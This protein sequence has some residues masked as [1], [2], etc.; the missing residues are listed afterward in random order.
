[1]SIPEFSD[2]ECW[3]VSSTLKERYGDA[4]EMQLAEAE[5]RLDPASETTTPCPALYWQAQ[6]V[7]FAVFKLGAG[8]FRGMF[9]YSVH[10]QYDLGDK[11]YDELAECVAVLLKLQEDHAKHR[12]DL[13]PDRTSTDVGEAFANRLVAF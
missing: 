9:F 13:E 11:D 10:D 12:A 1:M 6:G 8:R 4:P 5:L 7:G 2:A 3:V